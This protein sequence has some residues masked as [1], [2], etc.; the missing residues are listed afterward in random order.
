MHIRRLFLAIFAISL[1]WTIGGVLIVLF[2]PL[3]KNTF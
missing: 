2:P 1:F 3:V